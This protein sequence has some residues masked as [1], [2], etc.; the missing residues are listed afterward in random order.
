M[1]H[2]AYGTESRARV[3]LTHIYLF[4]PLLGIPPLIPPFPS[5]SLQMPS[6][7]PHPPLPPLPS[8]L[9]FLPVVLLLTMSFPGAKDWLREITLGP[10]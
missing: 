6:P 7:L 4:G 5:N 8:L 10:H 3:S 2:V 1:D 9:S